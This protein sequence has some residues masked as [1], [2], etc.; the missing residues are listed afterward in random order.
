V[1]PR[2]RAL[3]VAVVMMTAAV[4]YTVRLNQVPSFLSSDETAFD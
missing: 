4:L 1:N 3:V 2:I